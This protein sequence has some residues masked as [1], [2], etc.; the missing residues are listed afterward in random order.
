[1]P[2]RRPKYKVGDVL[3][4]ISWNGLDGRRDFILTRVVIERAS[5]NETYA[6]YNAD[7]VENGVIVP[8]FEFGGTL[9]EIY[10]DSL[11]TSL[12]GLLARNDIPLSELFEYI[13]SRLD[14]RG[15]GA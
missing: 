11:S 3:Y 5:S 6:F 4:N 13:F 1:M 14:P 12:E 8:C 9:D 10:E 15:I 7:E 2:K